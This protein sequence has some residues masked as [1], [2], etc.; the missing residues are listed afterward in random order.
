MI[1]QQVRLRLAADGSQQKTMHP[2][3]RGAVEPAVL[4]VQLPHSRSARSSRASNL[5]ES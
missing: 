3:T 4:A 2:A 5:S 1:N